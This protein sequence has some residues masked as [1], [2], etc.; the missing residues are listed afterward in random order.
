LFQLVRELATGVDS[1]ELH[2]MLNMGIG[3][4]VLCD[5][6]RAADVQASIPEETWLI[7]ELVTGTAGARTV[8]L[9]A[10]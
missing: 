8:H 5:P 3:M 6:A 10:L 4:V 1:H 7:G 9:L 2:R